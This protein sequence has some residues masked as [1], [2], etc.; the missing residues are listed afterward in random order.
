MATFQSSTKKENTSHH[1]KS[2]LYNALILLTLLLFITGLLLKPSVFFYHGRT[3][4]INWSAIL[5][6][7][8]VLIGKSKTQFMNWVLRVAQNTTD[9]GDDKEGIIYLIVLGI[10]LIALPLGRY[11]FSFHALAFQKIEII[12]YG[13]G[14]LFL[15]LF[16]YLASAPRKTRETAIQSLVKLCLISSA[17]LFILVL[18][19]SAASIVA[20]VGLLPDVPR[21]SE[22]TTMEPQRIPGVDN[23]LF[24]K[25]DYQSEH[26]NVPYLTPSGEVNMLPRDFQGQFISH[27]D[28]VRTTTDQPDQF[29]HTVYL[30]GGST[31]YCQEVSD[32]YTVAS[33]LQRLLNNAYPETYRV[34]NLGVP[35]YK[36]KHQNTRLEMENL[37]PGDIVIYYDGQN[38]NY[39]LPSFGLYQ[40]N[41]MDPNKETVT[42][43]DKF[44]FEQAARFYSFLIRMGESSEFIHYLRT[45]NWSL[46]RHNYNDPNWIETRV[47]SMTEA[48]HEEIEAGYQLATSQGARFFHYIQPTLFSQDTYTPYEQL[49]INSFGTEYL[50]H[51]VGNSFVENNH[52]LTDKKIHSVDLTTILHPNNRPG[53]DI[54]FD[55]CHVNYYGNDMIARGIFTDLSQYLE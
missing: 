39:L 13:A 45:Y 29:V 54:F 43:L 50:Y 32:Y 5:F 4:L 55:H 52:L 51:R 24:F 16:S 46:H 37:S 12:F 25:T 19:E 42:P 11:L 35:F 17:F 36:V 31:I 26:L 22:I 2:N 8:L 53:I 40:N 33:Y 47:S 44:L 20:G 34:V 3:W 49:I 21:P 15:T 30:L 10:S 23:S 6:V 27:E 7:V 28:G 18:L 1:L 14:L 38:N 9:L 48:Y 41:P